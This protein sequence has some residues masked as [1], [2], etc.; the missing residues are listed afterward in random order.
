M[1]INRFDQPAEARFMNTFVPLPFDQMYQ[2][3]R[4]AQEQVNTALAQAGDTFSKWSEFQSPFTQD[5][6]AWYKET[7]GRAEETI[8]GLASNLDRLKSAEGR[9][10]LFGIL[11]NLNYNRLSQLKQSRDA[12]LARQE[13][14]ARL[15]AAGKFNPDWHNVDWSGYDTTMQGVFN[16]ISPLAYQDIRSLVEPY[17]DSIQPSYLGTDGGYDYTG[18]TPDTIKNVLDQNFSSIT[19]TPVAQKHIEVMMRNNPGMTQEQAMQSFYNSALRD[20]MYKV[21]TD[22]E[23]NPY[24]QAAFADRL[25]GAREEANL[26]LRYSY[27]ERIQALKNSG[28]AGKQVNDPGRLTDML[29][30][31]GSNAIATRIASQQEAFPRIVKGVNEGKQLNELG[32]EYQL[33]LRDQYNTIINDVSI[34]DSENARKFYGINHVLDNITSNISNDAEDTILSSITNEKIETYNGT[35]YLA[36]STKG[37]KLIPQFVKDVVGEDISFAGTLSKNLPMF[38]KAFAD[39]KFK[40]VRIAGTGQQVT[41]MKDGKPVTG[42]KVRVSVPTSELNN[43]DWAGYDKASVKTLAN[44]LGGTREDRKLSK[45]PKATAQGVITFEAIQEIP[46]DINVQQWINQEYLNKQ[47][48]KTYSNAQYERWQERAMG[49]PPSNAPVGVTADEDLLDE[50]DYDESY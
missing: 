15:A 47:T 17:V 6:A 45:D 22:R 21:V 44:A 4:N 26:N 23:A 27:Q 1:A 40:N 24:A 13:Y 11:N 34:S 30:Y 46:N 48:S 20:S 2:L 32:T 25:R 35:D 42:I 16:D 19:G 28:R 41:Y 37:L 5:N 29:T 31:D 14:N 8:E 12:G 39:G 43:L 3:G 7:F 33:D 10:E 49:L 18:I 38:S 50:F 9:A 36:G